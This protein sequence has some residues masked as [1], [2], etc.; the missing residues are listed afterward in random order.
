MTCHDDY[1]ASSADNFVDDA[2]VD[3]G[4]DDGSDGIASDGGVALMLIV[5]MRMLMLMVMMNHS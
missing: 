4:G 3:A 1:A 5:L 2:D